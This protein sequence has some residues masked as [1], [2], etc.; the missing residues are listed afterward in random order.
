VEASNCAK[1]VA[2]VARGLWMYESRSQDM[3][4]GLSTS[5][6]DF[7]RFHIIHNHV[8]TVAR[9]ANRAPFVLPI[10]NEPFAV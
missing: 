4:G 7:P 9:F 6:V 5:L 8:M 2:V 3:V 10:D 1:V